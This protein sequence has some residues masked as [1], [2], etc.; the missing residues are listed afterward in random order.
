MEIVT[1]PFDMRKA[2]GKVVQAVSQSAEEKGL[3]LVAEVT[4]EVS[5]ITSDRRVE[6]IVI[7]LLN[8]AVKFTK[9]WQVCLECQVSDDS[10]VTLVVD[11]GIGIKPEDMNKLFEAFQ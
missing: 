1:K 5:E 6:Q 8:N 3:A 2:I 11:T 9:K 7:N 4:P 10:L